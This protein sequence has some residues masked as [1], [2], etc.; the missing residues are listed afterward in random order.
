MAIHLITGLPGAGKTY[1][2]V[3]KTIDFILSGKAVYTNFDIDLS[4]FPFKPNRSIIR[5]VRETKNGILYFWSTYEDFKNIKSGVVVCDESYSLFGSKDWQK[6]PIDIVKKFMT[7]R[8]DSLDI[9]ACSQSQKRIHNT[10]REI[11]NFVHRVKSF[12]LP[13]FPRLFFVRT[14]DPDDVFSDKVKPRC[15]G[16]DVFWFDKLVARCYDTLD[17]KT[18]GV[19][20]DN[21]Y[22]FKIL[23]S[24]KP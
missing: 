9:W 16:F 4:F 7:H 21:K 10:V 14:L 15:L 12:K 11:T 17:K 23:Y 2:L 1:F 20:I 3:K 24:P 22:K 18:M 19:D 5:K 8:H 13:L 6:L